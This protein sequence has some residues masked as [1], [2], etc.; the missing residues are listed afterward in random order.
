MHF[1]HASSRTIGFAQGHFTY[2]SDIAYTSTAV[3]LYDSDGQCP[4]FNFKCIA[5]QHLLP[6]VQSSISRERPKC[7][8]NVMFVE[9]LQ[10]MVY[11]HLH[12]QNKPSLNNLGQCE[13]EF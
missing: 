5:S 6:M 12:K 3:L 1:V 10:K 4:W 7:K 9:L 2:K 13:R 11:S 8:V